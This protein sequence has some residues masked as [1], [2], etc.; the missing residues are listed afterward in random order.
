MVRQANRRALAASPEPS[1][2]SASSSSAGSLSSATS[3]S[4]I[5]TTTSS[6]TAESSVASALAPTSDRSFSDLPPELRIEV[7]QYLVDSG[8]LRTLLD[9]Y[10]IS[11]EIQQSIIAQAR[12]TALWKAT[13]GDW[14]DFVES[15]E[16]AVVRHLIYSAESRDSAYLAKRRGIAFA[17][18][19]PDL[20]SFTFFFS[21]RVG[22]EHGGLVVLPAFSSSHFERVMDTLRFLKWERNG[23]HH[24][25]ARSGRPKLDIETRH[26]EA[27][28]EREKAVAHLPKGG[29]AL[30]TVELHPEKAGS[31]FPVGFVAQVGGALA[32]EEYSGVLRLKQYASWHNKYMVVDL[33]S[34]MAK[35]HPRALSN[36]IL[37]ELET[38]LDLAFPSLDD[39]ITLLEH[40]KEHYLLAMRELE[41]VNPISLRIV[42]D[43]DSQNSAL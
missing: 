9:L 21:P 13:Q 26:I 34:G 17:E 20:V 31:A 43:N 33:I 24:K 19:H 36:E 11:R 22:R 29:Y 40:L 2:A 25:W 12:L 23:K 15:E 38:D 30:V 7:A 18:T 14:E 16:A 5:S 3:A 1:K 42:L 10:Q 32:M 28:E 41:I 37:I 27:E 6:S 35:I 39:G 8:A 4:S